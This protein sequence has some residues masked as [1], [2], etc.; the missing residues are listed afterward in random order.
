MTTSAQPMTT[1]HHPFP[2]QGGY[3]ATLARLDS[4]TRHLAMVVRAA[5]RVNVGD[6]RQQLVELHNQVRAMALLLNHALGGWPPAPP[7]DE[8]P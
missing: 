6:R 5:E 1:D 7:D 2:N 8:A 3:T 4:A